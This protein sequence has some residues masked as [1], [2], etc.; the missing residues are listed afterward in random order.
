MEETTSYITCVIFSLVVGPYFVFAI[1][2][3]SLYI[4]KGIAAFWP[5]LAK[6]FR[7]LLTISHCWL[8]PIYQKGIA[9]LWPQLAMPLRSSIT[10]SHCWFKPTE[11]IVYSLPLHIAG[12]HLQ[13]SADPT[14]VGNSLI[15]YLFMIHSK[16]C[17]DNVTFIHVTR[18]IVI[19]LADFVELVRH[20]VAI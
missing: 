3:Y 10:M 19:L 2:D 6:L 18:H 9:V 16:L 12:K 14:I 17:S 4:E 8:K 7:S 20:I 5:L 15:C 13:V 1:A 11:E